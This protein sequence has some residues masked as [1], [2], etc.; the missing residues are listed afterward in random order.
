MNTMAKQLSDVLHIVDI[1]TADAE[2]PQLCSEY[3]KEIYVYMRELE[4]THKNFVFVKLRSLYC[5]ESFMCPQRTC[6]PRHKST[7]K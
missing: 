1:D 3:V 5:R 6:W 7:Q 2:N 4:V